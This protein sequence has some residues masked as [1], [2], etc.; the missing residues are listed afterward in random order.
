MIFFLRFC[1]T[2][3]KRYLITSQT[4]VKHVSRI[5]HLSHLYLFLFHSLLRLTSF[6]SQYKNEYSM[7][8]ILQ[9]HSCS[10]FAMS[11]VSHEPNHTRAT[12]ISWEVCARGIAVATVNAIFTLVDICEEKLEEKKFWKFWLEN[13]LTWLL[14]TLHILPLSKS[15]LCLRR[16]RKWRTSPHGQHTDWLWV[17]PPFSKWRTSRQSICMPVMGL[18]AIYQIIYWMVLKKIGQLLHTLRTENRVKDNVHRYQH[19]TQNVSVFLFHDI[20]LHTW[21]SSPQ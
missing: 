19:Q 2:W 4:R 8:K 11:S 10:T 6:L 9:K 14:L 12:V 21:P 20:P 3:I 16:F 5:H 13:C 15:K 7:I 18:S 1:R 17:G